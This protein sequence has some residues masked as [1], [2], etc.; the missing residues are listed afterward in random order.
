MKESKQK[1]DKRRKGEQRWELICKEWERL[2]LQNTCAREAAEKLHISPTTLVMALRMRR[3]GAYNPNRFKG[4][5][6]PRMYVYQKCKY[7][8]AD[9]SL[10]IDI[11]AVDEAENKRL[12]KTSIYVCKSCIT[13]K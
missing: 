2:G 5:R 10:R 1:E 12:G 13:N 7:C 8:G 9:T 3:P 6:K 4:G 11:S